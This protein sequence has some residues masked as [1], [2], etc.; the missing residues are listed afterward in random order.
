M[1][2]LKSEFETAE[3]QRPEL[4]FVRFLMLYT[5]SELELGN[6]HDA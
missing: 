2:L 4:G 6:V 1:T 3:F 5:E